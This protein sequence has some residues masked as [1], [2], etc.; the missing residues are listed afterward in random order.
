MCAHTLTCTAHTH[1]HV[2]RTRTKHIQGGWPE[3]NTYVH[4]RADT[5]THPRELASLLHGAHAGARLLTSHPAGVASAQHLLS[6]ADSSAP[7]LGTLGMP[8]APQ[9]GAVAPTSHAGWDLHTGPSSLRPLPPADQPVLDEPTR[10]QNL[11]VL[12]HASRAPRKA[13][14]RR[15]LQC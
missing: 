2:V 11:Q 8:E 14:W 13:S 6:T 5:G 3:Q 7:S 1:E 15:R 4:S 9:G 10:L 12:R